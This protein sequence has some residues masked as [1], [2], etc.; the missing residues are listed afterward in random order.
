[1]SL[2]I[3]ILK[4]DKF[5]KKSPNGICPSSK[6]LKA[7]PNPQIKRDATAFYKLSLII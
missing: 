5:I 1:M 2:E 6:S 4:N 3:A 7:K